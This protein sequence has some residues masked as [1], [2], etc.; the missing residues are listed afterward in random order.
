VIKAVWVSI[1][2]P[3]E[4]FQNPVR[5]GSG[6]ELE[7]PVGLR[8]GNRIMINTGVF[9]CRMHVYPIF[10]RNSIAKPNT[11][12]K[13]RNQLIFSGGAKWCNFL[14]YLPNTYVFKNFGGSNCPI[15]IPLVAG[16]RL[17]GSFTRTN[18]NCEKPLTTKICEEFFSLCLWFKT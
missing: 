3:V 5:S 9:P 18:L 4:F 15:A 12:E 14:L 2:N 16:L 11:F 8:S 7:N 17:K 13:G 6:S 1:S 10:W